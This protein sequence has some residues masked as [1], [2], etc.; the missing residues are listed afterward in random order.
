MIISPS[1]D[2]LIPVVDSFS[3][4]TFSTWSCSVD[5]AVRV[6]QLY[7]GR[8]VPLSDENGRECHGDFHSI[9]SISCICFFKCFTVFLLTSFPVSTTRRVWDYVGATKEML[10][11][12]SP[13]DASVLPY[14]IWSV[15]CFQPEKV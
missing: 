5:R 12:S 8:M 11:R 4:D 7:S 2:H 6:V 3:P 1:L 9:H 13:S 10:Y 15:F 14:L